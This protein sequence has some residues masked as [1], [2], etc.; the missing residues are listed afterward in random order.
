MSERFPSTDLSRE[1]AAL[2][3][4]SGPG[5]RKL[6]GL[7]VDGKIPAERENG[8]WFVRRSDLPA[9]AQILGLTVK[10]AA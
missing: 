10:R 5:H 8:R 1:L 9:V 4:N 7:I 6:W 2:T 3:G